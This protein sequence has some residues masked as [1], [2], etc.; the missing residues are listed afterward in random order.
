MLTNLNEN[1]IVTEIMLGIKIFLN[2]L[3]LYLIIKV[4]LKSRLSKLENPYR[5]SCGK[6]GT[7]IEKE[8]TRKEKI[9][10]TCCDG[11]I[12]LLVKLKRMWN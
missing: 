1:F 11:K 12:R 8:C 5:S 3:N 6:I 4:I 7:K 9:Q 10:I 2:M